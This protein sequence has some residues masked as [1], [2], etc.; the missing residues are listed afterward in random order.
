MMTA[1]VLFGGLGVALVRENPP[2]RTRG[3]IIGEHWHASYR[4]ELCGRILAPFPFVEGDIHSHNDGQVHIHPT[5]QATA[6][7]NANLNA[8]FMTYE[9]FLGEMPTGERAIVLP[10]GTRFMD[11][12]ECPD[13]DTHELEVLVN[14]RAIDGNPGHHVVHDGQ[15]IIVRFGPEPD[16]DAEMIIPEGMYEQ[17]QPP[18]QEMP[19]GDQQFSDEQPPGEQP[20]DGS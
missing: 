20:G 14:G 15:E 2:E 11:G 19:P 17:Q 5:S 9:S 16:D 4:A 10:D 8:F 7:D 1:L 3:A 12:D 18:P 13:G 6:G